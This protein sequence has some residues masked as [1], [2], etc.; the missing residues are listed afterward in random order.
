VNGSFRVGG[1]VGAHTQNVKLQALKFLIDDLIDQKSRASVDSIYYHPLS[2]FESKEEISVLLK[3]LYRQGE[4]NEGPINGS[5]I[6]NA[7]RGAGER[8]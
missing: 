1:S 6:C 2:I 8:L 3:I 7:R 4:I 5:W